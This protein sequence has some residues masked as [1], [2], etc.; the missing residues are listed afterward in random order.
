MASKLKNGVMRTCLVI[1]MIIFGL[2][3][4]SKGA[5]SNEEFNTPGTIKGIVQD[6]KLEQ[7]LPY[8]T[9]ALYKTIDSSLVTGTITNG[10][11]NFNLSGISE[12]NYYI[13]IDFIG[14]QK[15][16]VANIEYNDPYQQID[17][18]VIQLNPSSIELEEVTIKNNEP[19]LQYKI[20]RKVVNVS[21]HINAAGGSA[22]DVLENT[23]SVDTDMEGNVTLRGSSNFKVL[24]D[25]KPTIL[26]GSDALS[27]LPASAIEEIEIITNPSAKYDPDGTAGI[28]NVKLKKSKSSG[29]TGLISG[30]VGSSPLYSGNILLNYKLDKINFTAGATSNY[31]NGSMS[32]TLLRENYYPDSTSIINTSDSGDRLRSGLSYFA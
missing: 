19:F 15:I 11:G 31:N 30:S 1:S 28:I 32:K 17:L 23:P 29:L 4:P 3:F 26:Q 24:I 27:Q 22:I 5:I 21:Q 25:G 20:D 6:S 9:V 7:A 14:F 8:A 10:N 13:E 16:T 2:Y 12:G 18:G